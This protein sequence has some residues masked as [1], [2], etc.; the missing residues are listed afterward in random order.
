MQIFI[1]GTQGMNL[2][3]GNGLWDYD[4]GLLSCLSLH[5]VSKTDVYCHARQMLLSLKYRG[6]GAQEVWVKLIQFE[7]FRSQLLINSVSQHS[8]QH[9]LIRLDYCGVRCIKISYITYLYYTTKSGNPNLKLQHTD[10][11]KTLTNN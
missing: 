11:D 10:N 2:P 5:F 7:C 4:H 3:F 8:S 9:I 6:K 1:Y